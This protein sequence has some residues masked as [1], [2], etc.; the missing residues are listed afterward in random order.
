MHIF[1]LQKDLYHANGKDI[2]LQRFIEDQKLRRS[3]DLRGSF[4]E[5]LH[6]AD[7]DRSM[8]SHR[9]INGPAEIIIIPER[10]EVQRQPSYDQRQQ[11]SEMVFLY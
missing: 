1:Y 5:S 4:H 10:L 6:E 2:L 8:E 7:V 3:Q 11:Q 9:R